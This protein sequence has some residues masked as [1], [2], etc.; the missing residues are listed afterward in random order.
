M[1]EASVH[2]LLVLLTSFSLERDRLKVPPAVKA[3]N[4]PTMTTSKGTQ[5]KRNMRSRHRGVCAAVQQGCH[6]L[7]CSSRNVQEGD[8][9][10]VRDL[11]SRQ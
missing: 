4:G 11:P 1:S 6:S 9:G 10:R 8:E 5:L 2:V 7:L 3:N